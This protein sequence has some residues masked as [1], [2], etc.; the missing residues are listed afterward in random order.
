M[1]SVPRAPHAL[2]GLQWQERSRASVTI[3]ESI[4]NMNWMMNYLFDFG[5]LREL[6]QILQ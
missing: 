3:E 2:S 6:S 5:H 4:E 1:I